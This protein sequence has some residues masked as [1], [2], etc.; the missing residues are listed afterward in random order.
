MPGAD[1]V[2][3]RKLPHPNERIDAEP[4]PR[5]IGSNNF[6]EARPGCDQGERLVGGGGGWL[7]DA[8]TVYELQGTLSTNGP[9]MSSSPIADGERANSVN[10]WQVSG[11]NTA[12]GQ[13]DFVGYAICLK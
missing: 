9:A 13:R 11:K 3:L 12:G 5:V 4:M 8:G 10:N 2:D 6:A 1:E 7:N